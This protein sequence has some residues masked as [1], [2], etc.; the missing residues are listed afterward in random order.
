MLAAYILQGNDFWQDKFAFHAKY[1]LHY[2]SYHRWLLLGYKQYL[3]WNRVQVKGL[4]MDSLDPRS[5]DH[6][7]SSCLYLRSFWK[8]LQVIQTLFGWRGWG[9][10]ECFPA[11]LVDKVTKPL[12]SNPNLFVLVFFCPFVQISMMWSALGFWCQFQRLSHSNCSKLKMF[13][14]YKPIFYTQIRVGAVPSQYPDWL[15]GFLQNRGK[16][17]H[18]LYVIPSPFV[19]CRRLLSATS[20][21]SLSPSA[22]HC[23]WVIL[24]HSANIVKFLP[25][26]LNL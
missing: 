9:G 1:W 6:S 11:P 14:S 5:S 13:P 23:H 17:L 24:G 25:K 19:R 10:R 3:T 7:A 2:F 18:S 20:W 16:G 21:T 22:W 8:P 4:C 12:E 15:F 26:K